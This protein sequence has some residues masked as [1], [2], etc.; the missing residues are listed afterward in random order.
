[1]NINELNSV[2]PDAFGDVFELLERFS[3]PYVIVSGM[4]VLLHGHKRPVFD[5]DIVIAATP[6]EQNR[7][8]HALMMAGFVST[9]P[10]PINLV[11]VLRMFDQSQREIDVFARY[12]ISFDQLWA[13]SVQIV[14]GERRVRVASLEHLLQA[15]RITGRPHGLWTLKVCWR[16]PR[17]TVLRDI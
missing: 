7:A 2:T 12:H 6:D 15:K 9:I 14:V 11:T 17:E 13:D 1:M 4:A 16:L 3:A 5:L 8:Q 10:I